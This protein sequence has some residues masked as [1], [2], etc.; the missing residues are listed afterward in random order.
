MPPTAARSQFTVADANRAL[1][2]V[3][4][5]VTDIVAEYVRMK[6]IGRE[7]RAVEVSGAGSEAARRQVDD[8]KAEMEERT[9]R[10]DSYIKEL[11]DLGVEL[12][13]PEKGLVD[14]PSER[15][16]RAVW[17]CW[18]LGEDGVTHWHGIDETYYDRRAIETSRKNAGEKRSGDAA[19]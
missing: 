14:F 19:K 16:G 17:L 11:S 4:C 13:D 1:P 2:L 15:S 6:E 9:Q 5:I 10:I 3:R 8:L 7:R 12:K 18:R